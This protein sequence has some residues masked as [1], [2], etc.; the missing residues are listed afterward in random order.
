MVP[1]MVN[2]NAGGPAAVCA[3]VCHASWPVNKI[4]WR[5]REVI[6]W[7][8]HACLIQVPHFLEYHMNFA[9]STSLFTM[10]PAALLD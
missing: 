7:F 2:N 4:S 5:R 1:K 6:K 10:E 3:Y 8:Y 9:T